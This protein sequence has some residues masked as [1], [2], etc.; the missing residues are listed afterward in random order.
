M[1]SEFTEQRRLQRFVHFPK[2]AGR[3]VAGLKYR[4]HC[5]KMLHADRFSFAWK[6]VTC[7]ACKAFKDRFEESL[8][9]KARAP[10]FYKKGDPRNA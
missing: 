8:R 10:R 6:R 9:L 3:L 7:Y 2:D 1:A 5:G 4:S